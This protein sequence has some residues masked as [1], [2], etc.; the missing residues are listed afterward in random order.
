M[1]SKKHIVM[2]MANNS[3]VP[4][5]TWFAEKAQN[6]PDFIF[7]FICLHRERP[8]MIEEFEPLGIKTHWIYF[9]NSKRIS[10]MLKAVFALKKLFQ[11][12]KPDV[13]HSHLFD[14]TLPSVIAAT[15]A[16]IKNRVVTKQDT[17]FHW[18]YSPKGVKYD[19]LINR[20]AKKLI[21][22]SSE[23]KNFIIEKEKADPEKVVL[24]HHGVSTKV[25]CSQTEEFK[26]ELRNKYQLH[27]K[28]VI[29]TVA[30]LIEWKGYKKIIDAA[31]KVVAQIP[32]TVFLFVGEGDQKEELLQII[33]Q[34]NL[35]KNIILTGWVE[36]KYI[37][38][39]YGIAD[40]YFHMANFEPFGFVFAEA[41]VNGV[42]IVSNPT[43]AAKDG[44]EN[45]KNGYLIKYNDVDAAADSIL[46]LLQSD[47]N[48]LRKNAKQAGEALY[49]FEN[50]WSKHLQ[51]YNSL[52]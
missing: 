30:R 2:I 45:G 35:G 43:G 8:A 5:F 48:E 12:I 4:Y 28:K 13:V 46:S 27:G 11:E 41:L 22:V 24:I 38:S 32:E 52:D 39:L 37:P 15:W 19:R 49:T 23:C 21:A 31:E 34:K 29:I 44:I 16:G 1:R 51:L 7:S 18:Y 20:L 10:S 40:I 17:T 14:D 9:D 42:P 36:R 33:K 6:H 47:Q 25:V 50:M 26:N 3:S